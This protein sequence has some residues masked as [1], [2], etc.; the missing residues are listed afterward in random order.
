MTTGH[1]VLTSAWTWGYKTPEELRMRD[2]VTEKH[3]GIYGRQGGKA[4]IPMHR[5]FI[6]RSA[7]VTTH[8]TKLQVP[9]WNDMYCVWV[10]RIW[11]TDSKEKPKFGS[12]TNPE[13]E[14]NITGASVF[15]TS[16]GR[17]GVLRKE[18]QDNS[19]MAIFTWTGLAGKA[20]C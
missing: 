14:V 10:H 9:K 11:T 15:K 12:D 17:A 2:H 20:V 6:N 3:K 18:I 19:I 7:P 4:T 1:N 13:G 16:T 5:D 8:S